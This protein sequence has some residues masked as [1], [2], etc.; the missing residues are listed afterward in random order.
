G[1]RAGGSPRLFLGR[2]RPGLP[3]LAASPA[4][5]A[6]CV[7]QPP[8]PAPP[9]LPL[10]DQWVE[11]P[12]PGGGGPRYPLFTPL[13]P[14]YVCDAPPQRWDAPRSPERVARPSLAPPDAALYAAL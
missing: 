12:V 2:C 5:S 11:R 6:G 7:S 13:P 14:A 4:A 10:P 3:A 1:E 9:P 8:T